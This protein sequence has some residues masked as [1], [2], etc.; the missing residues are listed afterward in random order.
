VRPSSADIIAELERV[1]ALRQECAADASLDARSA[2]IKAYQHQ[3][4]AR[5][6]GALL[7][8][9]R[10]SAAAR[11]FLEQ[12]YGPA[13]FTQRDAEFARVVPTMARL[14][15]RDVM[16][17]VRQLSALHAL[18]EELDHEMAKALSAEVVDA[19][20]YR[21]AWSLVG[22]RAD[23]ERQLA[24]LLAIGQSLDKYARQPMLASTLRLM[25]GAANAA[26]LGHLQSFLEAGLRAFRQI[27]DSQTFLATI[28]DNERQ[29]IDAYFGRSKE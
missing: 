20:S 16:Q 11:F 10:Y 7:A 21:R 1:R 19:E 14:L 26:G 24:L 28:A 9:P 13:D 27:G 4:F 15:P 12:L 23:R 6:Y 2:S 17:T 18:T 29:V 3:R 5:D 22:R 8:H 25:R